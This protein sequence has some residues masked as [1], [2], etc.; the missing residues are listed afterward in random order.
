MQKWRCQVSLDNKNT[1]AA[2]D[3]DEVKAVTVAI[4]VL[5]LDALV[6]SFCCCC[7]DVM[8]VAVVVVMLWLLLLLLV[9]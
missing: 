4:I 1:V 9:A 6:S 5:S 8:V 3:N 7:C 2:E